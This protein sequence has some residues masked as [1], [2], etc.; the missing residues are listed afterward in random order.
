M[1]K[2]SLIVMGIR[3]S[4]SIVLDLHSALTVSGITGH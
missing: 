1:H 2:T 4:H 3:R